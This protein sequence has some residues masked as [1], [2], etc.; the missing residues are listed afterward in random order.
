MLVADAGDRAPRGVSKIFI[1]PEILETA[2]EW[3]FDEGCLSVPGITAEITRPK[4]IRL[5][6]IDGKGKERED[7]FDELLAR[8]LL[9]EI[10]HLDGKLFVD[11]LSPIR[12]AM[13]MKKLRSLMK[14]PGRNIPTL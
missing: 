11:Y 5:R 10:D 12:R 6:Y 1:N 9:H 7:E 3:I 14:D 13:I 4:Q 8:V 2:G